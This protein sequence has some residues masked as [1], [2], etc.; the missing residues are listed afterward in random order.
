MK[1]LVLDH[2]PIGLGR[3]NTDLAYMKRLSRLAGQAP[4]EIQFPESLVCDMV[5]TLRYAD[6]ALRG[7]LGLPPGSGASFLTPLQERALRAR[8]QRFGWDVFYSNGRVPRGEGLG[9]VVLFDYIHAPAET[10]NPD[11]FARDVAA[12]TAVAERCA[13]VQV[14]T[15]AQ[16]ALF[17]RLDIA[18][19]RLHVVPF[20]MPDLVAAEESAVRARQAADG[21]LH[22]A[23]VG[24]QARR[25]G[26]PALLAALQ[27]SA[28]AGVPL[29]LTIVSRFLDCEVPLPDDPRI[30][31]HV[32]LPHAAV[33]ALFASAQ[34]LAVPSHR[35]TFGLVYMEG[36]AA[37][38]ACV[39]AAGPQQR[40]ISDDGRCGLPVGPDPQALA[41]VLARLQAEPEMRVTLALAG[42]E[43][44]CTVYAPERVAGGY[45]EMF[46]A[47]RARA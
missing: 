40:D 43:R 2:A 5:E 20:F 7:R 18:A 29:K 16:R 32:E 28:L 22:I 15:E 8:R 27:D 33:Q 9:P 21:D 42:L 23:F 44:F 6:R 38:C 47:V 1:A 31:R 25:K 37:G 39:M 14:S 19:D 10:E 13:A 12:K 17:T 26:L 11:A 35:E 45:A 46:R 30:T 24:H 3:G 36:M 4:I 41:E 34:V